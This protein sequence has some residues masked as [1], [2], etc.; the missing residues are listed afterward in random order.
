[1]EFLET[2]FTH[3]MSP[4]ALAMTF[5]YRKQTFGFG[6]AFGRHLLDG[7]AWFGWVGLFERRSS[8]TVSKWMP[9]WN[10]TVLNDSVPAREHNAYVAILLQRGLKFERWSPGTV[11]ELMPFWSI[12]GLWPFCCRRASSL[13][14]GTQEQY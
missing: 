14:D 2:L 7:F 5:V 6:V 12:M 4:R 11:F 8:E 9:F 3:S 1:M 10:I 13:N